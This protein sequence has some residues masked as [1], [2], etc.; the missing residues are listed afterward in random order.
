MIP[1]HTQRDIQTSGLDES[2]I[3]GISEK[4]Q[5][6]IMTILRDTL[7]TDKILAVLREY[8]ANAWDAHR[9]IGKDNVPIKITL[10]TP[11]EPTLSIRDYGPGLS[12]DEIF[13]IFTQYG[14]STKR[15]SDKSVGMLGIGS[16]SGFAYSD[17]FT[18][19][20]YN[21]GTKSTYVAVLD[22][23]E[24]GLLT[25]LDRQPCGEETGVD[26]QIP[27]K[28]DD[29]S[30]F[31]DKAKGLFRYFVP[32]PDINTEV[33]GFDEISQNMQSGVLTKSGGWVAV[34]GCI[35]YR[36]NIDQLTAIRKDEDESFGLRKFLSNLHGILFFKIGE[37]QINASR[38][39]LKYS[40]E[41]INALITRFN[42]LIEEYVRT[43]L[44]EVEDSGLTQ[45][46]R[47]IRLWQFSSLKF[48]IPEALQDLMNPKV[49]VGEL[50][51]FSFHVIGSWDKKFPESV[52]HFDIRNHLV[53]VLK[54]DSR[55][56]RGFKLPEGALIVKL[57]NMKSSNWDKMMPKFE[58]IIKDLKIQGVRIVR[59]SSCA[60]NRP[61]TFRGYAI[62]EKHRVSTFRFKE[63]KRGS[64]SENWTIE[65]HT[66]NDADVFVIIKSF[67]V[68]G[69]YNFFNNYL[70]MERFLGIF[71]EKMPA[72]YGYKSTDR[73]PIENKDVKGK[74]FLIWYTGKLEEIVDRT[75]DS[76]EIMKLLSDLAW[77][78][79]KQEFCKLQYNVN[80]LATEPK[81]NELIDMMGSMHPLLSVVKPYA[82][83][84]IA[85]KINQD[86]YRAMADLLLE[87]P[88]LM[89]KQQKI[90][91]KY[92][93]KVRLVRSKYPLFE[94]VSSGL[95]SLFGSN[96]KSWI[97][98]IKLIDT[99]GQSNDRSS[100]IQPQQGITD[101]SLGGEEPYG[102]ELTAELREVITGPDE[103]GLGQHPQV[104]N[105]IQ[106]PQ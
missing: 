60:F 100:S 26:I 104:S 4:D 84:E 91:W 92:R 7:Y 87:S 93:R 72:V 8:S 65:E 6:H 105:G 45:I 88:E 55:V 43:T 40:D 13:T 98:Y 20:S 35:P 50:E 78:G 16:K 64:G 18:I 102:S 33:A 73:I 53:L 99:E 15:T 29:I 11:T 97:H 23:S 66:P 71:G 9:M 63:N 32:K 70:K 3:F 49:D 19:S 75:L 61:H 56:F 42:D 52:G 67:Y 36:I 81:M 27:V 103:Q 14:A 44:K 48:A 62:N 83:V 28:P 74:E 47:R 96:S 51:D 90:E 1:N 68:L 85:E 39:E 58:S 2:A 30:Q 10:P 46:E 77:K 101:N 5:A 12:Q 82:E 89:K 79:A 76:P 80:Y 38:E 21:G 22:K 24:K 17:S 69:G 86:K 37:V 106:S 57:K 95:S 54:D 94:E 34:M 41:T 31:I 59:L 25:L